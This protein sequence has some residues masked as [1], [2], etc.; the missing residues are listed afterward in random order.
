MSYLERRPS[1]SWSRGLVAAGGV[2]LVLLLL[3]ARRS[4]EAAGFDDSPFA[5]PWQ[6]C[7]RIEYGWPFTAFAVPLERSACPILPD[8]SGLGILFDL[9]VLASFVLLLG[10][11]FG[12]YQRSTFLDR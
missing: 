1:F 8:I 4:Y 5:D 3:N 11:V 10:F 2:A 12:A 9:G 6:V 7:E